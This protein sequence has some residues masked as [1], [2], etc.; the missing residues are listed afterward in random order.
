[1]AQR[2]RAKQQSTTQRSALAQQVSPR[3]RVIIPGVI[4]IAVVAVLLAATLLFKQPTPTAAPTTVPTGSGAAASCASGG[5]ATGLSVGQCAP[6]FTLSDIGG[7]SVSLAS[8][9]GHP[10]LLHFWAVGCTTCRAEFPD[11]SRAVATY[12]PKGLKV[13]AVDAWGE[14]APMVADWQSQHHLQAVMLVDPQ[15]AIPQQY[16]V[17]GTP[18]TYF[19]DRN[20]RIVAKNTGQSTYDYFQQNISQII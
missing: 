2:Q 6:N 5:A 12:V 3:R 15:Q 18:T 1:M 4:A 9:S 8:Y 11:F 20:G 10:V 14:P 17:P 7:T 16:A 13:L 19:I